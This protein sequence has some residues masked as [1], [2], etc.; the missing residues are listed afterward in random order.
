MRN[1]VNA[2]TLCCAV[3]AGTLP[4]LPA[5]AQ[6]GEPQG[7]SQQGEDRWVPS[8]AISGGAA[9]QNQDGSGASS[10][11]EDLNPVPV[12]LQASVGGDDLLVAPFVGAA[13]EL[14]APALPVPTR[15]RLFVSGEI[16][17]SFN[18][19]RTLAVQGDPGCVR[20]PEPTAPCAKDE[21][22]GQRTS[23]FGEVLARAWGSP[24]RCGSASAS[25]A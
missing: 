20:G 22:V 12:T 16:L 10:L 11:F 18:S 4:A 7:S 21:Q 3:A 5:Q 6:G 13:L 25:C 23:A 2:F 19:E 1:A 15:P 9:F 17:P 8:F 14:M 24:S